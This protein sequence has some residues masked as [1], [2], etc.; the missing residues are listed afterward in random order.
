MDLHEIRLLAESSLKEVDETLDHKGPRN[1][2]C[3]ALS[4]V[5]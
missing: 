2:V 4:F 5:Y 3:D 1:V